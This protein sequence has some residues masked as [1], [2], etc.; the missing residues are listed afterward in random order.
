MLFAAAER[1]DGGIS[2]IK[3]GKVITL[4]I[5][6]TETININNKTSIDFVLED[7]NKK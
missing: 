7:V 1:L 2:S 5:G 3:G 4:L 6:C